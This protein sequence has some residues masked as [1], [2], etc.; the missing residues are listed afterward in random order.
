MVEYIDKTSELINKIKNIA[1]K[2][3]EELKPLILQLADHLAKGIDE[4][5]PEIVVKIKGIYAKED[6]EMPELNRRMVS[7][8]LNKLKKEYFPTVSQQWIIMCLPDDYKIE[9]KEREKKEKQLLI[10]DISDRDLYRLAPEITRR[11]NDMKPRLPA[12]DIKIKERKRDI[13][14]AEWECP[15]SEELARLA[16]Q[17][18]KEHE[19]EHDHEKCKQTALA[20]RMARDKRF[21]TTWSKYQAII[22]GA[23]VTRSLNNMTDDVFE[24]LTRWQV[25]ENERNCKEC[26]GHDHCASTKCNHHCHD[27]KKHLTT[28]GIKWVLNHSDPLKKLQ[29]TMT[30]LVDD[31]DDMC[32]FMKM[33][34]INSE[35]DAKMT[36]ADKKRV[37]ASHI[38]K[39]DCDKCLYFTTEVNK[40]WFKQ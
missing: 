16:I 18:E 38:Q 8:L 32:D 26:L 19:G 21:A 7:Q 14:F 34:F 28:K 35:M 39:D 20:V 25:N 11:L 31:S 23:E 12:K 3:K 33:I 4:R 17:C 2:D 15:V 6:K 36:Q 13:E 10:S 27:F 9:Y 24:E 40:D 5:R 1:D 29:Q 37:M 22:V 30:K